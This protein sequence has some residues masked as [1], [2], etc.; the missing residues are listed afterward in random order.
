MKMIVSIHQPSYFPWLGLLHKIANSDLY[1]VMDEVQLSDS[2]YQQ[3]NIFL[4][5]DGK[6]KYLTIPFNK[7][8][9]LQRPFKELEIKDGTWRKR[10]LDFI[11]NSYRKHPYFDEIYPALESYFARD[12]AYLIDA[13][14]ASMRMSLGFFGIATRIE[15]QSQMA[16]DRLS[17]RGDLVVSLVIASGADCYLS[18]TGG[19][20]YLDEAKFSDGLALKYNN[21]LHPTYLQKNSS[22]FVPGLAC[23]DVL[24]NLGLCEARSFFNDLRS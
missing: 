6:V 15:M 23:L 18:G 17:K 13:V 21:F 3:R 12:Y 16:Y 2:A 11:R 7:S 24:F 19:K 22:D 1:V 4:S 20:E 9:Y 10:H 14:M 5:A 8:G